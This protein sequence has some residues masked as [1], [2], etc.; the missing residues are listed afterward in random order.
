MTHRLRSR[1]F[2]GDRAAQASY[3]LTVESAPAS[4]EQAAQTGYAPEPP[5]TSPHRPHSPEAHV[6]LSLSDRHLSPAAFRRAPVQIARSWLHPCRQ[7]PRA[8]P[9]PPATGTPD[10]VNA[11][12][13]AATPGGVPVLVAAASADRAASQ[14]HPAAGRSGCV[15]CEPFPCPSCTKSDDADSE[16]TPN[17]RT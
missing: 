6:T 15:L 9:C 5:A 17:A 8:V 13:R 14:A 12:A 10:P 3:I 1:A 11:G 2:W 7:H 4:P 16:C